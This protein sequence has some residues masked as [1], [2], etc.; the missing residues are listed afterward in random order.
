VITHN[1]TNE[2]D[3]LEERAR[4]LREEIQD[5]ELQMGATIKRGPDGQPL[6]GAE[7]YAWKSKAKFAKEVRVREYRDLKERIKQLNVEQ[8]AEELARRANILNPRDT[9]EMLLALYAILKRIH[10][11]GTFLS[12]REFDTLKLVED[13]FRNRGL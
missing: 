12:Q 4:R 9:E 10:Q 1:R 11:A 5:I 2:R 13:Y 8:S 3:A 7:F 6:S